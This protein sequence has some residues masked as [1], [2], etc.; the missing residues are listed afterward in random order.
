MKAR[1]EQDIQ[2]LTTERDE[3]QIKLD[4][5]SL[6]LDQCGSLSCSQWLRSLAPY[7]FTSSYVAGRKTTGTINTG[8][9]IITNVSFLNIA[10]L[11]NNNDGSDLVAGVQDNDPSDGEKVCCISL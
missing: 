3:L 10:V 2:R 1:Y 7:L 11:H 4:I 9:Y 6:D 5:I 8:T